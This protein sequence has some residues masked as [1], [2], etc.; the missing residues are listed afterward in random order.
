[1]VDFKSSL[2]TSQYLPSLSVNHLVAIKAT[3][4]LSGVDST[5]QPGPDLGLLGTVWVEPNG[6]NS[7]SIVEQ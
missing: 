4:S 3:A 1:M 5:Q 2:S 7:S 6:A